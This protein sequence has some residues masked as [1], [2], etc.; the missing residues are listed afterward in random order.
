MAIQNH[1]QS[2]YAEIA[3]ALNE[4]ARAVRAREETSNKQQE[5][6]LD[7]E[8]KRAQ[9]NNLMAWANWVFAGLVVAQAFSDKFDYRFAVV[10]VVLFAVGY[11]LAY[12]IMK[13][14][15]R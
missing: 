13:G 7:V 5:I 12:R 3:K 2:G 10:G 6:N 11:L 4:V 8:N 1:E 14:G 15:G 9:A